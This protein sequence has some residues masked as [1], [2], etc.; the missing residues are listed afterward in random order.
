MSYYHNHH[1]FCWMALAVADLVVARFPDVRA[2]PDPWWH[3]KTGLDILSAGSIPSLDTFSYTAQGVAWI[4]HEW[5]SDVAFAALFRLA[6]DAGLTLGRTLVLVSL[7]IVLLRLLWTRF[8]HPLLA[9][10]MVVLVLQS[11]IE[12]IKHAN[13]YT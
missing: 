12:N 3:V 13:S 6:G 10:T 7:C 2:D 5:L 9:L 1:R 11:N 4:N 8:P